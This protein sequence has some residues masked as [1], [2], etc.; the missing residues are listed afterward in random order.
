LDL[1]HQVLVLVRCALR[2]KKQ[3]AELFQQAFHS[4][5]VMPECRIIPFPRQK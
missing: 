1:A 3:L 4:P 5:A 2:V